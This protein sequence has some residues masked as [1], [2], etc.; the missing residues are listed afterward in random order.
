MGR[1][2]GEQKFHGGFY[3]IKTMMITTKKT[4]RNFHVEKKQFEHRLGSHA[5]IAEERVRL[6]FFW[7]S[8]K[9]DCQHTNENSDK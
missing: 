2:Y 8:L 4:K 5:H 1:G 7:C 9:Y 3:L 6:N